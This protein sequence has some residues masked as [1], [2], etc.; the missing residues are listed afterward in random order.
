MWKKLYSNSGLILLAVLAAGVWFSNVMLLLLPARNTPEHIDVNPAPAA[1][2]T[3]T[4]T[5]LTIEQV[6]SATA[7]CNDGTYSHSRSR[8]GACSRHGGVAQWFIE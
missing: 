4:P 7:R 8:R 1:S 6:L 2:P 3:P 5:P